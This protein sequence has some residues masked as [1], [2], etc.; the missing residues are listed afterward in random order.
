[1]IDAEGFFLWLEKIF[2]P[3]TTLFLGLNFIFVIDNVSFYFYNRI[4]A[5]YSQRNIK[6]LYLLFYSLDYNPIKIFFYN[7]KAYICRH[8]MYVENSWESD[9]DWR[10][11]LVDY[12]GEVESYRE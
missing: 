8:I 12:V 1:M 4:K 5:V 10:Q 6:L 3:M 7:F 11:F 9:E 2:L